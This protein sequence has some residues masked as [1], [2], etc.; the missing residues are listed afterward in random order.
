MTLCCRVKVVRVI[1]VEI[2]KVFP[3]YLRSGLEYSNQAL[4]ADRHYGEAG[5]GGQE[6]MTFCIVVAWKKGK[7]YGFLL[8]FRTVNFALFLRTAAKKM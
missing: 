7:I 4:R 5:A 1:R 6:F 3:K 2:W 8:I